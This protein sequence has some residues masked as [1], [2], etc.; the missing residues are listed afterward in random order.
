AR[1]RPNRET[2][3][4]AARCRARAGRFATSRSIPRNRKIPHPMSS[5]RVATRPAALAAPPIVNA[6]LVA[7]ALSY[8]LWL[9]IARGRLSWP[10]VELLSGASVLAGCLALVGPFVLARRD[11]SEGGLGELLWLTGGFLVWVFDLTA[12]ARGEVR[13]LASAWVNPLGA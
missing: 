9:L 8:G 6:A 4:C 3:L 2:P 5:K 10:P 13:G 1:A 7:L 11:S 12:L